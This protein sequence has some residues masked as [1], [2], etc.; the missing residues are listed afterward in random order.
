MEDSRPRLYTRLPEL[1]TLAVAMYSSNAAIRK[2]TALHG[3]HRAS[4][5]PVCNLPGLTVK[6]KRSR[7]AEQR[8]E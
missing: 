1:E 3:S 8:A 5:E 6:T 2:K 7:E 4:L